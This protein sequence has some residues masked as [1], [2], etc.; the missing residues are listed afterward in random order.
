MVPVGGREFA[1]ACDMP[2][3]DV[4]RGAD[5]SAVREPQS[6]LHSSDQSRVRRLSPPV[7]ALLQSI[8]CRC[9]ESLTLRTMG[10]ELSRQ[11]EYLGWL[12]QRDTGHTFHDRLTTA[13]LRRATRLL[14]AGEKIEAVS[15][16]VGYRA[17][18]NFY[19]HFQRR[20]QMTPGEYRERALRRKC[21]PTP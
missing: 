2:G 18:K 9:H 15:L 4:P 19:H 11:P 8:R 7:R 5:F 3:I 12:F 10:R 14:R 17:K 13:R 1:H 6:K 20:F 16:L 21:A